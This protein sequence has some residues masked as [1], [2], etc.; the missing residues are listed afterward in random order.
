MQ[1]LSLFAIIITGL[2]LGLVINLLS[3]VLPDGGKPTCKHCGAAW[4]LKDYCLFK[5]CAYCRSAQGLRFWLVMA[6]FIAL[7]GILWLFP[8]QRV[9]TWWG[10]ILMSYF[11]VVFVIDLEHKLILRPTNIAGVLLCGYLGWT[12]HGLR[13]TLLGGLAG[14]GI[15]LALYFFGVLF[16]RILSRRRGE[17]MDEV[18]LGFGD[19]NLSLI[20]GLLLGW[21][22]ITAG[23]FFAVLAG[24]LGS[25]IYLLVNKLTRGYENFTAIPYAPFLLLGAAFL[26]FV[27][28]AAP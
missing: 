13:V 23:L 6:F 27:L 28:P 7:G 18:A 16:T 24:G 15:M 17:P 8:P 4:T 25:G 20:L 1:I 26:I 5:P 12:M 3:D 21:P 22:G 19:V 9:G 10:M 11:G 2:V 14:F